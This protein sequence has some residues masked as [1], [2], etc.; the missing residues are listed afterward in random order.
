MISPHLNDVASL[1]A[2]LAVADHIEE[3]TERLMSFLVA[4]LGAKQHPLGGHVSH[5]GDVNHLAPHLVFLQGGLDL[6]TL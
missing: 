6:M 2:T 3:L 1:G 5:V 4:S